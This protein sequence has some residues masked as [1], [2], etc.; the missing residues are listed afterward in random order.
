M[1][2]KEIKID[3][4]ILNR[5]VD[6]LRGLYNSIRKET[7]NMYGVVQELNAMW[8]GPANDAFVQQFNND[9]ENMKSVLS[10]VDSLIKCMSSASRDYVSGENR[11]EDIVSAIRI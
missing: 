11:V 5:D 8:D 2:I 10:M 3:T 7:D 6:A 4:I 1:T 9:Y